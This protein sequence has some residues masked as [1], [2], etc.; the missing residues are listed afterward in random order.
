M[1]T[2]EEVCEVQNLLAENYNVQIKPI[3]KQIWINCL[4]KYDVNVLR[5]CCFRLIETND[6]MP[7]VND[8][9]QMI[10]GSAKEKEQE[11]ENTAIQ[12]FNECVWNQLGVGYSRYETFLFEDPITNKVFKNMGGKEKFC[13]AT[14]KDHDFLENKFIKM[15]KTLATNPNQL[16]SGIHGYDKN[17]VQ[18]IRKDGSLFKGNRQEVLAQLSNDRVLLLERE[19][20]NNQF[21][22]LVENVIRKI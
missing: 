15:Y 12:Q 7:K 19:T 22:Q 10:E 4:G 9:V 16:N 2:P 1:A 3:H 21:M 11:I 14:E 20:E 6:F 17:R 5:Q 18:L 8:F 13:N